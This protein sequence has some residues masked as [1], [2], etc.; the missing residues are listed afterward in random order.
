MFNLNTIIMRKFRVS[1]TG[2]GLM[3]KVCNLVNGNPD[4]NW[5]SIP[6]IFEPDCR[7][8]E[9]VDLKKREFEGEN[10]L[11]MW[12]NGE[13]ESGVVYY[14]EDVFSWE[15]EIPKG[16]NG[17]REPD[18]DDGK[19]KDIEKYI[20]EKVDSKFA[21]AYSNNVCYI[22]SLYIIELN[23]DEDLNIEELWMLNT[24]NEVSFIPKA[25]IADRIMYKEDIITPICIQINSTNEL[26]KSLVCVVEDG[27]V[28]NLR[29][30][31]FYQS[32]IDENNI[33]NFEA[34][35]TTFK[36]E[37]PKKCKLRLNEYAERRYDEEIE[38]NIEKRKKLN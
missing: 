5:K 10:V 35:F 36:Y 15:D 13:I 34:N 18:Y 4:G 11:K 29:E 26:A 23:D 32:C 17:Y 7:V 27:E 19:F 21:V 24:V 8:I 2:M 30:D 3:I 6:L 28:I 25:L 33:K 14:G 12:E 16:D 37:N 22:R 20:L 9:N 38:E 1:V 31:Q